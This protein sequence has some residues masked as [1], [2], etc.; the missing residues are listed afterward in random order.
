MSAVLLVGYLTLFILVA[1]A[2]VFGGL[3]L[4]RFLRPDNPTPMKRETYECGEPSVGSADIQFDIRF[5]VVALVFLIFDVEVAL[6]F[7]WATVFG[8]ATHLASAAIDCEGRRE[9]LLELGLAKGIDPVPKPERRDRKDVGTTVS[10]SSEHGGSPSLIDSARG[11]Q[12]WGGQ[13]AGIALCDILVFFGVLMVGFAY[14]WFR[15]DLTW[16][17]AVPAQ[18]GPTIGGSRELKGSPLA[19]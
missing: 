15:G 3:L 17:R 7:P 13:L 18:S 8:K 16:V 2:L 1:V 5:Y 12:T 9:R 6:F 14:V 4:G 10:S 19:T 11:V